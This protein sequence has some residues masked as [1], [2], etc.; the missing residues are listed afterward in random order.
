MTSSPGVLTTSAEM[1]KS[2]YLSR[3]VTTRE[4]LWIDERFPGKPVI[5]VNHWRE[6]D[7]TLD[8]CTLNLA[9]SMPSNRTRAVAI[10]LFYLA[11]LTFLT[12]LKTGLISI[13]DVSRGEDQLTHLNAPPYALS[14]IVKSAGLPVVGHSIFQHPHGRESHFEIYHMSSHGALF[15]LNARFSGEVE[16]TNLNRGDQRLCHWDHAVKELD[17]ISKHLT[18][19]IGP[20]GEREYSKVDLAPAYECM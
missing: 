15:R 3:V 14:P 11:Q 7:R 17:S 13:Y 4:I 5:G 2:G 12:S 1:P 20:L 8:I 18:E 10:N 9:S 6:F 16:A 19:D